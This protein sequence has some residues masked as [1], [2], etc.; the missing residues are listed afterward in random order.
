MAAKWCDQSSLQKGAEKSK[1]S[2]SFRSCL[3]D[4]NTRE[5]A[6]PWRV[7]YDTILWLNSSHNNSHSF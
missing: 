3:D 6:F 4:Q 7:A 2:L 1:L 5:Y